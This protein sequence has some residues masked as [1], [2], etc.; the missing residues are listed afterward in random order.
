MTKYEKISNTI[1]QRIRDG[2]Y[3]IETLIPNQ[4]DL[5]E[6]FNVS[7]MTVK[8][9]MDILELEGLIYRRR[10]SGTYVKKTALSGGLNANIMEY[11]GLTQQLAGKDVKSEIISFDMGFPDELVQE[12]LA[13][14]K[15]DPIYKIIR[16]RI[17]DEKPY[18]L[19]H[20]IMNANLIPGVDEDV[21][22]KSVYQY[23]HDELNLQFGGAHRMIHA[24]KSSEIDQ[25]YLE[26]AGDD[27]VLEIEQVVYLE[28]GTPFE[29]S[30]SRNKY[31]TRSY[32]VVDLQ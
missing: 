14:K 3:P 8:R 29:Y 1:R 19:E 2:V 26:C 21:L 9:A 11:E 18:M 7:R 20:T 22:H 25:E 6:E 32:N 13:I 27:P 23:I 10:G 24:D 28:D 31:D 17:V 30:R 12:K 16:L 5:A 15:H 4:V